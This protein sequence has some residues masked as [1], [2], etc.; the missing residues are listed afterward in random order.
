MAVI[1]YVIFICI[2]DLQI[3]LFYVIILLPHNSITL[4]FYYVG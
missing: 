4:K 1:I 2:T 3:V